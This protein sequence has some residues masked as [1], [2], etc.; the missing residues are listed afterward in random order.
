MIFVNPKFLFIL[1]AIPVIIFLYIKTRKNH[2]YSIKHPRVSMSK[3]LKS[4]YYVKDIPFA[5]IIIALFLSIIALARPVKVEHLSDINGEGIYISL[6]VDVSPS[7]MAEDMSPTRLEASKR[8]MIDFIKK[9]NFDKISLVAFALRASVLLP[10]TS[11][12]IS[13]SYSIYFYVE[14]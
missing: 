3:V 14:I 11:S 8:T 12:R 9:R 13:N 1:F 4:K 2:S 10:A 7:M 5:L 6:V